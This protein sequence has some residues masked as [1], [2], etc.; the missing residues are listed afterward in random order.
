MIQNMPWLYLEM[1]NAMDEGEYSQN[2]KEIFE[3][4]FCYIQ[5]AVN[6]LCMNVI[7]T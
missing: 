3:Y 1:M 6:T 5:I 2:T 4:L 7:Y